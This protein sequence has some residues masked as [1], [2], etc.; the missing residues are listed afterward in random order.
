VQSG[1]RKDYVACAAEILELTMYLEQ[2]RAAF[3]AAKE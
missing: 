2:L 3:L 1:R